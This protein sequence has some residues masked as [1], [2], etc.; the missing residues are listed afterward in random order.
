[1]VLVRAARKEPVELCAS[2]RRKD[3]RL[4]EKKIIS[5]EFLRDR[6]TEE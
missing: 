1:M 4:P 5:G 6:L 2:E 3:L